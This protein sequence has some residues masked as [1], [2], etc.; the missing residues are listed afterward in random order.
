MWIDLMS[1]CELLKCSY[2]T[3][4]HHPVLCHSSQSTVSLPVFSSLSICYGFVL[5]LSL[6]EYRSPRTNLGADIELVWMFLVDHS[7]EGL[8]ARKPF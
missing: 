1:P 8:I 6:F 3:P 5:L 2:Q 7:I 4:D